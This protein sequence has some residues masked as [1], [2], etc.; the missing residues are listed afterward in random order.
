MKHS[1]DDGGRQAAA[2]AGHAAAGHALGRALREWSPRRRGFLGVVLAT[3]L[4]TACAPSGTGEGI[5]NA[6]TLVI[7]DKE[8]PASLDP[9]QVSATDIGSNA[10]FNVYD[11]LVDIPAKSSDLVPSL[12]VE[13]PTT[14]NGLI[15]KDGLTY[16]F[17]LRK[18]VKFH[19]G[20]PLTADSVKYSW[21]RVMEMNL[22][23]SGA[24]R[25][26]KIR[27]MT[28][29]DDH[30]F[31]VALSE[32]DGSFLRSI[33]ASPLA[34]VVNPA[35]VEKN[36]GVVAGQPNPWM[37]RNIASSG[38]Y[39]LKEW[40][41]GAH[42]SFEINEDY[43]GQPAR[44]P[45]LLKVAVAEQATELQA[46]AADIISMSADRVATVRGQSD[47]TVD[48]STPGLQLNQLGFNMKIDPSSLPKGDDIPADFFQDVRVRK[49]FNYTF[50]YNDYIAGVLS[51]FAE[52]AGF[53]LPKGM[54]GHDPNAGMYNTDL[55]M[56]EKLF[57]ESGWWDR[58]FTMSILV[59]GTAAP[60][61]GAALALKDAIEKLNPKFHVQVLSVPETTFDKM[62]AEDPIPAAMWSYTSPGLTAP[63]DYAADQAHPDGKWGQVGG[64]RNGYSDPD[65]VAAL[66][67]EA[68]TSPDP[69]RQAKLYGELSKLQY[70]EAM[71]IITAQE[72]LP[73]AHGNW[74]TGVT[75]N[76]LWPRPSLRWALYDKPAKP[77][78]R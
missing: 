57:R 69:D 75:S 24:D 21:E 76:P 40:V 77:S 33:A 11:R 8:Q 25:M 14:D 74:V 58:G 78:A 48:T 39:K 64:F 42:L 54:F 68:S 46:K 27:Q 52:R 20:S 30:T 65:R 59:D 56:A 37:T 6:G 18:D 7:A 71:W 38:P 31:Q 53:V 67:E 62:M 3:S 22:P 1:D 47:I 60:F 2:H 50:P 17:P 15:S 45:V 9:A 41:S 61:N 35:V 16:T 10:V 29:L 28:A 72:S 19:D 70:D 13:V 4:L 26:A 32:P 55:S 36:G 5:P 66:C 73:M 44:L 34:S 51:G 43:W 23:E 49:A 12:A 63:A